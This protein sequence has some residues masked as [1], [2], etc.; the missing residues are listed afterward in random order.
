[1]ALQLAAHSDAKSGPVGSNGGQFWSFRP[2]RPLNKIVL[3]FSGSPDQTLN[4]ISITFSSN[5]T[6]IITVGGVGPEPLTYTETVNIDG[7]IIEISGMIANYKGYNVIRSIKFSTNKKEYG[8]YGANAGTPFNI[9]IPEGNKIVGFFG[10]SGWYVDAIG[11][12]YAAK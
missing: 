4:L 6:D 1:M 5:P 9:K 2:V 8:P 7:D 11:A 12:Y 10:N 3:S